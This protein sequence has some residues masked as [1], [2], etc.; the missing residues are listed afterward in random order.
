VNGPYSGAMANYPRYAIY[1]TATPG[2]APDRFGT[3]RMAAM[4]CPFR[5]GSHWT[6]A[7]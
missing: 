1:Y 4:T 2:S 3:M 5:M 6:G 7:I